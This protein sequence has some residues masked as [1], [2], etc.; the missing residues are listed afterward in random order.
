MHRTHVGWRASRVEHQE[1]LK[2]TC[3]NWVT[4]CCQG[5]SWFS[6]V[7]IHRC[8]GHVLA[9]LPGE[10][11]I[12]SIHDLSAYCVSQVVTRYRN[13]NLW[14]IPLHTE[15]WVYCFSPNMTHLSPGS[16]DL[17]SEYD[18]SCIEHIYSA[19]EP[20]K[21]CWH[22]IH[23]QLFPEPPRLQTPT[24]SSK[25]QACLNLALPQWRGSLLY[26]DS[27]KGTIS[28]YLM[29]LSRRLWTRGARRGGRHCPSIR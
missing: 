29:Q 14:D 18:Q 20:M 2:G 11:E 17:R 23:Q 4:T 21:A 10:G 28:R 22:S 9:S 16:K 6:R 24:A 8:I 27:K 3:R 12:A 13:D 1:T 5:R 26:Q 25:Q 7:V 15:S 19:R